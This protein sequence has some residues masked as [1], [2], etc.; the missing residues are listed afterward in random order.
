MNMLRGTAAWVV[1]FAMLILFSYGLQLFATSFL[2]WFPP[3]S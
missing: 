2:S 3:T 1:G